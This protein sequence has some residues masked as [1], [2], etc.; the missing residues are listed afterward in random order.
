MNND[1]LN[2][3]GPLA[4]VQSAYAAITA[5]QHLPAEDQVAGVALLFTTIVEELKLNP[6]QIIGASVRRAKDSDSYYTTEIRA[7]RAYI[8]GELKK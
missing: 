1:K 4:A 7:L 5:I 2:S 8:Q 3:V 6:Y